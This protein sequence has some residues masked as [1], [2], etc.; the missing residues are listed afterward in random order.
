LFCEVQYIK[1][2]GCCGEKVETTEVG[3]PGML[4]P[5][6]LTRYTSL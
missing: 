3:E 1:R 5:N 2:H 6:N 4:R